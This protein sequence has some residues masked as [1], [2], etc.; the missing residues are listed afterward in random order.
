MG[1]ALK[2]GAT[3]NN[4][5]SIVEMVAQH[6]GVISWSWKV[7]SQQNFDWL[8][9]EVDGRE[10]AGVSAKNGTWQTQAAHVAEGSTVR[11]LYRKDGSASAGEDAGYI[12]NPSIMKF[13]GPQSGYDFQRPPFSKLSNGLPA[14][15]GWL[16]ALDF[17][18]L[19]L[20]AVYG[21][22]ATDSQPRFRFPVS[23]AAKGLFLVEFSRDLVNWSA[24]GIQQRVV[25]TDSQ[26][27]V[28]EA[29]A[30]AFSTGFFRLY[31]VAIPDPADPNYNGWRGSA[32]SSLDS[33][34]E[35]NRRLPIAQPS[36]M[37]LQSLRA[38]VGHL[39]VVSARR[40]YIYYPYFQT[41]DEFSSI[42]RAI[43]EGDAYLRQ[44]GNPARNAED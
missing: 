20:P 26:R 35:I 24:R 44:H 16:G 39:K 21:I 22:A 15:A 5:S 37:D 14:I 4:G 36:Q 9:C 8:L 7:S 25:S 11:W 42:S 10:V 17:E 41:R 6:A 23:K 29:T 33:V 38:N 32:R 40:E 18:S 13:E 27:V 30:P 2:S 31:P 28:F 43:V 1:L 19:P 12:T 3:P 34:Y